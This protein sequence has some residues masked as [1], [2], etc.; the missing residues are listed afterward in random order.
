MLPG[1]LFECT[2]ARVD[3]ILQPFKGGIRCEEAK[4][5]G[6]PNGYPNDM[7]VGFDRKTVSHGHSPEC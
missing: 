5:A 2:G 3:T 7:T 4:A 6:Y 1:S